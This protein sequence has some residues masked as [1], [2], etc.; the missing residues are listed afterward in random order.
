[1]RGDRARAARRRGGPGTPDA[2]ASAAA[3]SRASVVEAVSSPAHVQRQ[4]DQRARS[5]RV[6]RRER[7]DPRRSTR[8]RA[9]R[10]RPGLRA[11]RRGRIAP[12]LR[13]PCPRRFRGA[14]PA[15]SLSP[16]LRAR[17]SRR[18]ARAG[19]ADES[20]PPP[21][22]T[23]S[24]PPPPPPRAAAATFAS[25]PG[26]RARS[27]SSLVG[28]DDHDRATADL[29]AER[30]DAGL[31]A[32]PIAHSEGERADVVRGPGRADATRRPRGAAR[33]WPRRT[34]S[35]GMRSASARASNAAI[36]FSA[37]FRLAASSAIR[38]GSWSRG[39]FS[40]EVSCDTIARSA[41]RSRNASSPTSASTRRLE[42]P[43]RRFADQVHQTDLGARRDMGAGAQLARP[44]AA[45]VDHPDG[46]AVLL[47]E[48]RHR[49]ERLRLVE[50]D[51][52]AW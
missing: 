41:A 39:V 44:G 24:R 43:D 37:A 10:S 12:P 2:C 8:R 27:A 25:A 51:D 42:A 35:A 29:G 17:P 23:S 31:R 18:S 7:D 4:A 47:A 9:E 5:R 3:N 36:F 30:D 11:G 50:R 49:A 15:G 14:R 32:E 16:A 52:R 21:C 26:L 19:S 40:V 20:V 46:V 48:Q 34:A 38:A 33:P 1:M 13:A 22:A 45:D 6:L 28:G